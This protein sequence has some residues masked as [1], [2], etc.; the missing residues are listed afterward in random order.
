VIV[1]TFILIAVFAPILTVHDPL[2]IDLAKTLL[3]PSGTHFFGTDELGR[4]VFSRVIYG[5]RLSLLE[6]LVA[7]GLAL[8]VG[9]PIGLV[10]G[11]FGGRVDSFLMRSMDVLMA[12]PGVLLAIVV[13][14]ILGASLVNAMIAVAVY[15]VP[16]F[17]RMARASTLTVKS[18]AYI[19]ACAAAGIGT[20][21]TMTHHVLPNIAGPLL[22][23]S[24]M[25]MAIAILT[26]SSLSFLGLGA[27][28]PSPEWGAMLA[29]GRNYVLVGPHLVIFPGLAIVLLVLGLNFLQEGLKQAL[30]PK[31][32]DA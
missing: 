20:V 22:V 5:A 3:P 29:N 11:Y 1:G 2:K 9:V 23:L 14:S 8:A 30:D 12:F 10:A 17:A 7:V 31:A 15:T 19:E 26:A 32:V 28:P 16:I 27:Q 21:R 25:R 6:G 4:D 24:A 13:V 18:E